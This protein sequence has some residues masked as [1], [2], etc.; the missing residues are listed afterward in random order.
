MVDVGDAARHTGGLAEAEKQLDQI[1]DVDGAVAVDVG[2]AGPLIDPHR[3]AVASADD[4]IVP[5]VAVDVEDGDVVCAGERAARDGRGEVGRV[6]FEGHH[7]RAPEVV[8]NLEPIVRADGGANVDV[9]DEHIVEAV[10]VEVGDHDVAAESDRI[11]E[12][13]AVAVVVEI[14]Q[15]VGPVADVEEVAV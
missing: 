12:D 13:A 10:V 3:R 5:S 1:E 4:K 7:R 2:R 8:E 9:G 15:T 14:G 11:G 6:L